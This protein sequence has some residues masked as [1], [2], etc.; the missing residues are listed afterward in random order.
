MRQAYY[1]KFEEYEGIYSTREKAVRAVITLADAY[2]NA[3]LLEFEEMPDG[4]FNFLVRWD[5]F[6]NTETTEKY[7]VKCLSVDDFFI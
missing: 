4:G 7:Y 3:K 6:T 5:E 2:S 1:L